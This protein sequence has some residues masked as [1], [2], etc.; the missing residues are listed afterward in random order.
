MFFFWLN[1]FSYR[2][3]KLFTKISR[4]SIET[5]KLF[6]QLYENIYIFIWILRGTNS[7]KSKSIKHLKKRNN[8]N[9]EQ[10]STQ[11]LYLSPF[12]CKT[13]EGPPRSAHSLI[14]SH[15]HSSRVQ[16]DVIYCKIM[17]I[18]R[19]LKWER[20]LPIYETNFLYCT[21]LSRI[22]RNKLH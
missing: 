9:S 10:Y 2:I 17:S 1:I 18:R 14:F 12:R 22:E 19:R 16:F 6:C 15:I 3:K 20:F 5:V 8:S 21:D 4:K 11:M 13:V 7:S